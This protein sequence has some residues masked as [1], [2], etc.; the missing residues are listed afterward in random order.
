MKTESMDSRNATRATSVK[1]EDCASQLEGY[2]K[3]GEQYMSENNWTDAAS[4]FKQAA[5]LDPNNISIQGK[6]GFC[7]SRNGQH[8]LSIIIFSELSQREPYIAKWPYMIGYQYY[9][10]KDWKNAIQSF[11]KALSLN[12]DYIKALYRN[13]YARIQMDDLDGAEG[14]LLRCISSWRKLND[15]KKV[16]EKNHYS[17][18]C[19]Q[20][21]K[22][23][24]NK[25]LTIKAEK[26]LK[27]AVCHDDRDEHKH[28]NLGKAFLGNKKIPEALEEF[29]LAN[30]LHPYLDYFQDK[31]A[32]TYLQAG[33]AEQA[34]QIYQAIPP[35]KRKSYIWCNYGVTLLQ[36]G[37]SEAAVNALQNAAKQDYNNHRIHFYLGSAYLERENIPHAVKELE[38]AAKLKLKNFSTEYKEAIEKIQMIRSQ[39]GETITTGVSDTR[40]KTQS[41]IIETFNTKRGFGFLKNGNDERIFFHISAVSNPHDIFPGRHANFVRIESDKGPKASEMSII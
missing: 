35:R 23:Y 16:A 15:E 30:T 31:L 4:A 22:V 39:F 3:K 36:K 38:L 40:V 19:F 29:K 14:M 8:D 7:Y 10:K 20:L 18:A 24:L 1:P 6:L 33:Q 2:L 5:E 32:Y 25:G 12:G 26:W 28:Y 34:E 9:D 27:E 21:G 11:D 41:A 37:K 13:G 17:D